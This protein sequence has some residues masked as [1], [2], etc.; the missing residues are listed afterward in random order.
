[1]AKSFKTKSGTGLTATA[2]GLM[3]AAM[4]RLFGY[5]A[6][7][8]AVWEQATPAQRQAYLAN[9]PL[10]SELLSWSEQWRQ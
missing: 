4:D 5:Y 2:R 10:L 1:M 3:R 7:V 8:L 9:S 6:P